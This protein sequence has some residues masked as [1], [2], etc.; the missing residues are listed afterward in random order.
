MSELRAFFAISSAYTAYII[1]RSLAAGP[2][3]KEPIG[4]TLPLILT[5]GLAFWAMRQPVRLDMGWLFR[6][7]TLMSLLVFLLAVFERVVLGV[8]RP[9]LLLG[10]PLNLTPLLLVPCMLVTMTQFAPS[11]KWVWLGLLSFFLGGYVIG[12]L[13]QS[14]GLFLGLGVL[15]MIRITFEML[16]PVDLRAKL[17]TSLSILATMGLLAMVVAFDPSVSNRYVAA[18]QTLAKP[19]GEVEWSTGLR[20]TMFKEGWRTFLERP[21][22]GHGPQNRFDAVFPD[23][24]SLPIRLSHLHNDFLTHGVAGGLVA[25]VLLFLILAVP[26][27]AGCRN[28]AGLDAAVAHA[29]RQIGV[30]TSCAFVGVAVVNN[31]FFVSI[32]AFTTALSLVS[33]LLI[34]AALRQSTGRTAPARSIALEERND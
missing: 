24:S 8:W 19:A 34:L 30:L 5:A 21:F 32:S 14:R 12:G 4:D 3:A 2:N 7:T 17:K 22:F 1:T 15:V 6:G 27:W 20:V 16:S 28:S 23:V 26:A 13:S 9:E 18:A 10:N 31:V 29:R 11:P 25:V 33:V